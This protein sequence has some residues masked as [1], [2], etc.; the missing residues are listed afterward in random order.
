MDLGNFIK[1]AS[2]KILDYSEGSLLRMEPQK[3]H[4]GYCI[5]F[6][7]FIKYSIFIWIFLTIVIKAFM[8]FG[9]EKSQVLTNVNHNEYIYILE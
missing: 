4:K 5:K 3:K 2:K 8:S 7:A 9:D 1:I 6:K